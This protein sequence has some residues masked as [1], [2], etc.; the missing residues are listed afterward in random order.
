MKILFVTLRALEINSSVT[1]SNMGLIKG[2]IDLGYDID[3]LMPQ[4][5]SELKQFEKVVSIYD[6]VNV[7]RIPN[8]KTYEKLVTGEKN[9]VKELLM[10][11]LR[12]V[13]YKLSIH[14]NTIGLLKKA[15]INILNGKEYDIIISTSDPKTSH[16]FVS[17]LKKQGLQYKFWIQHWGDP[18]TLDITKE[19]IYPKWF[20]KHIEEKIIEESDICIYVSPLTAKEQK[21]AIQKQSNKIKFI[22]LP[23]YKEKIYTMKSREKNSVTIGYFGDYNSKIRDIMPLYNLC[24][25]NSAYK[26]II[27]GGTDLKLSDTK[28]IKIYPRLKQE[29]I[30]ELE[31]KCDILVCICNKCGT[32]IPGKIYYYSSTNKPILVTVDGEYNVEIKSY[33]NQYNRFELC[34]NNE[35]NILSTLNR[36]KLNNIDLKPCIEFSPKSIAKQLVQLIERLE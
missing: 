15:D 23:Y 36:I 12:K 25:N 34:D 29:E 13:F 10:K 16:K 17:I 24:N 18:M 1:I 14:D 31:E 32:Q 11:I 2:L 7:I 6:R 8:N 9:R 3:L 30:S 28:N 22:P 20:I 5:S 4:V 35:Q 33:L 27:A 21:K 26:L 19:S